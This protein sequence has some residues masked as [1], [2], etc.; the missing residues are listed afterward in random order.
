MKLS[1]HKFEIALARNCM[2]RKDLAKKIGVS[3]N[4]INSAMTRSSSTTLSGKIAKGLGV[5][6]TELL[7][8]D[9]MSCN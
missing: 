6:I 2:S 7:E 1:K 5:D 4:T 8:D 9:S 3:F